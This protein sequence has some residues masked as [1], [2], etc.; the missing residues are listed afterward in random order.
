MDNTCKKAGVVLAAGLGTRLSANQIKP[1]VPV[2]HIELLLRNITHLEN[3]GCRRAIIVLG[4]QAETIKEYVSSTYSGAIHL[5]FVYNP[6]Y[7]L[8]NGLSVLCARPFVEDVYILIMADHILDKRIMSLVCD[9]IPPVN[10][11]TLCVDYKLN[12]IFDI[13]D[14]TKVYAEGT[15]IKAIGKTLTRFNCIDIGVFVGTGGLMDA[16]DRICREKGDASLS[17]G[18][19]ALADVDRMAVLD[20]GSCF[21]QDVDTPEMLANAE[22]LL[23]RNN[24]LE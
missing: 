10:G 16:I 15:L 20:I 12:T 11:A 23:D 7:H 19:Q 2:G 8:S 3:I 24:K 18:V 21:W 6:E 1:L 4:W 5:K 17:E 9:H 22:K 14:A 13:D